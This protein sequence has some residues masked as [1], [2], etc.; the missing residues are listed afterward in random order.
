MPV[1]GGFWKNLL[2]WVWSRYS[3]LKIGALFLF[4][5][6]SGS[7]SSVSGCCMWGGSLDSSGDD[8][9]YGRSAWLD[10]GYGVCGSTWLLDEF[11]TVSTSPWTRILK[12]S[13]SVLTQNGEVC[14]ADASVFWSSSRC[15]HLG[16]SILLL[17]ASRGWQLW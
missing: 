9:V 1:H 3:H 11:H 16:I 2:S 7:L 13:L 5:L 4:D 17:R 8:F 6:V 15:S 12:C 10:S 14:S